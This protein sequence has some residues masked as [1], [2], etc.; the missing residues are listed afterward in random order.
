MN[1]RTPYFVTRHMKPPQ[2]WKCEVCNQYLIRKHNGCHDDYPDHC[3][4][5]WGEEKKIERIIQLIDTEKP[6]PKFIDRLIIKLLENRHATNNKT[7]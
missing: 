2:V 5:C 1:R 6:D 3:D 7:T 4:Q